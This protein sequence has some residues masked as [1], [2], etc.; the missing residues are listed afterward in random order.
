MGAAAGASR[1]RAAATATPGGGGLKDGP[2]A[3]RGAFGG[4]AQLAAALLPFD[5]NH[6]ASLRRLQSMFNQRSCCARYLIRTDATPTTNIP[7]VTCMCMHKSVRMH[8]AGFANTGPASATLPHACPALPCPTLPSA[9]L[10]KL[11]RSPSA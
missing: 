7:S 3:V 9:L 10:H 11:L 2:A 5:V 1:A 4:G 8:M 6:N